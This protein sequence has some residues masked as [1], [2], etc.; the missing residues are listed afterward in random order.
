MRYNS[1]YHLS[2]RGPAEAR[3][4]GPGADPA[5]NVISYQIT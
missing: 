2:I 5:G 1:I 4:R 3:R